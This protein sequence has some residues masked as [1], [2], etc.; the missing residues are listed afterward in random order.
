MSASPA[1]LAPGR[2]DRGSALSLGEDSPLAGSS[3]LDAT[4]KAPAA[5]AAKA[6]PGRPR[7]GTG[8]S[9]Q[10]DAALFHDGM[11]GSGSDDGAGGG[12]QGHEAPDS[13]LGE[14]GAAAHSDPNTALYHIV[15]VIAGT[16]ILQLPFALALS[17]WLGIL[18]IIF[19]AMV[20][21]YTGK[22]LIECLYVDKWVL[23]SFS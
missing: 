22:L 9:K 23:S 18:V 1:V 12:G 21:E 16:G 2:G 14:A 20:N 15:C 11:D 3:A 7:A 6:S 13:A 8:A 5:A 19:A 17:G 4:I 10:H